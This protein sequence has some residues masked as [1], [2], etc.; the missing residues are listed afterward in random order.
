MNTSIALI[1]G[2]TFTP[3]FESTHRQLIDLARSSRATPDNGPVRAQKSC[4]LVHERDGPD[5][6]RKSGSA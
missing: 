5:F 1:G 2:E 3:E 4:T 6:R